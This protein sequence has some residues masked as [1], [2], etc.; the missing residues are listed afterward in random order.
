MRDFR[1]F[2]EGFAH[3][4]HLGHFHIRKAVEQFIERERTFTRD[5]GHELRTPM[6]SRLMVS[7]MLS[8][9]RG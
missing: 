7:I 6:A 3:D 9:A 2:A 4:F 5:A 1:G 8:P